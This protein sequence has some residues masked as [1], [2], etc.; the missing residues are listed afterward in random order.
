M[1]NEKKLQEWKWAKHKKQKSVVVV[2]K[3]F[4]NF[5][6]RWYRVLSCDTLIESH[7]QEIP[8]A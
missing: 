1:K 3:L 7:L 6:N 2:F 5:D 8:G 4:R